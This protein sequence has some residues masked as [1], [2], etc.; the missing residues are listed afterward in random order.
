MKKIV[1]EIC[2][3]LLT[4]QFFAQSSTQENQ[5]ELPDLTT[6]VSGT[7][8]EED[9]APAPD[10]EDVLDMA[11]NSGDLVPQ[12]PS[13]SV[14]DEAEV[15]V[16]SAQLS[17]KDIYAEG[18]IGG[19]Y[20]AS[21]TGDFQIA[22][23]YGA[24]P[25]KISFNHE[26]ASGFAG[27]KLADGYNT[28]NTAIGVEKDFIRQ[29]LRWGLFA[30]Y[31]DLKDGFQ[32]KVEDI[33]ANNQDSVLVGGSL[34]WY[35][36]KDFSL[37]FDVNSEFY[38]RFADVIRGSAPAYTVVTAQP[39]L[40]LTW[41]HNGFELAFNAEYDLEAWNEVSNRGQFDIDF[42]WQNDKIKLFSKLGLVTG[43][44]IGDN[45]IV[46]PF[47][48]GLDTFLPVY[49]SDRKLNLSLSGG[50]LSERK[51]S[52]RLEHDFKFAC[53]KAFSSETTDWYGQANLLV[54]LKSSFTGN[55]IVGYK[56]TAFGNGVWTPDYSNESLTEGL[57]AFSLK[58][59]NALYTDF[60][61]TWKYKLFAA[62]AKYH[63]NWID[64]PS[65]E[66]KHTVSV[67]FAL[68]SQKGL[69]GVSLDTA[70]LLDAA[71]NKPIINLEGYM[72]VSPA[73]RICLSAGDLLKL[74]GAEER[75]YGGQYVANS[76]NAS[77]LVKFLF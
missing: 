55:V 44:Y 75:M 72:Q 7:S 77:L 47:T 16:E 31:E 67:N 69:W 35:L 76:G 52:S 20:P 15:S 73:V 48:L 30:R 43:N 38:Y 8:E 74:L 53:M 36:P 46:I 27:H 66:N 25:F 26:S 5:I 42:S 51:T 4:L 39:Q 23:L 71:D 24:D 21:F 33:A 13:V 32:G 37:S 10:F 11:Y 3:L 34:L 19:G 6:L 18:E 57:Y 56:R 61:F 9:F 64:I 14:T 40:G 65:L 60:A 58:N 22:R 68:Q 70:Y 12:L 49:F 50:I 29:K 41:L 17:Q 45:P 2:L 54:P 28:S 59:R 63:A 62:S 1:I